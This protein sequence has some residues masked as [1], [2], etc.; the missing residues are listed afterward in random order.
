MNDARVAVQAVVDEQ[1]ARRSAATADRRALSGALVER[2]AAFARRA[3]S[4]G[5]QAERPRA[6]LRSSFFMSCAP[7]RHQCG[8]ERHALGHRLERAQRAPPRHQQEEAEVEQRARPATTSVP[9]GDGGCV[10]R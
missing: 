3:R 4:A 10:P 5:E 7:A 8:C 2:N 9:A 1:L 6:A